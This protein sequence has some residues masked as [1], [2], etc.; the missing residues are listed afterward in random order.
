MNERDEE[1]LLDIID[2]IRTVQAVAS[3]AGPALKS[4]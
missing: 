4:E 2:A 1:L 3:G